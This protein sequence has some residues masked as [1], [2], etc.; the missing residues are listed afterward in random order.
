MEF[1]NDLSKRLYEFAIRTILFLR[2]FPDPVE[3]KVIK[4][5]LIKSCTSP[6]ANYDEA[7]GASSR[8][9]FHNKAQISLKEIRESNYWL[10]IIKGI[11]ISME[12]D[13]SELDF[14]I[15]ESNEL[16]NILGKITS[17]TRK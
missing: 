15:K 6:G 17:K 1:K 13:K 14:L 5:Q 9:D 2:N 4:Y 10:K 7:Q 3:Y 12:Y 11:S 16:M 8:A